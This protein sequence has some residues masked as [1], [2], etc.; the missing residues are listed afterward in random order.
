LR[1]AIDPT[2]P[3]GARMIRIA[4]SGFLRQASDRERRFVAHL[5]KYFGPDT[6][7]LVSQASDDLVGGG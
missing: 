7:P 1:D 2:S 3:G 5:A 6:D 4:A